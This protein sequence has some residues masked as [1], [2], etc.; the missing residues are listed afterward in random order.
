MQKSL[1]EVFEKDLIRLKKEIEL[2]NDEAN[3]WLVSEGISNSAGNLCSHII[4]NL[5]NYIG[6]ILGNTGYIRNRPTEFT[7]K[8]SKEDLINALEETTKMVKTVITNLDSKVF[9]QIYP[10]NVFGFEMKTDYFLIHLVGHLNYHLGQIN[11]HRRILCY[12]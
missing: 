4:G 3:L 2:Y 7:D 10:D 5:N 12:N 1:A 11:Y 8:V 6:A 9:E